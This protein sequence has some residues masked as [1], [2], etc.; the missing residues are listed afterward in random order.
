MSQS[1]WHP[2]GYFFFWFESKRLRKFLQKKVPIF[3]PPWSFW[4]KKKRESQKPSSAKW[5][6]LSFSKFVQNTSVPYIFWMGS[7][8]FYFVLQNIGIFL[9]IL[10]QPKRCPETC[11]RS[12]NLV[13][14]QFFLRHP[15]PR[16]R[17]FCAVSVNKLWFHS[18]SFKC[19]EIWK[20]WMFTKDIHFGQKSSKHEIFR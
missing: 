5:Y 11:L 16:V 20:S 13:F 15:A 10:W 14:T 2:V 18:Q 12:K 4:E 7:D 17:Q 6:F 9:E 19:I 3:F 8:G 1:L